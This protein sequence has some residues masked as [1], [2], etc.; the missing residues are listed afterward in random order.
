MCT[1]TSTSCR[2][3]PPSCRSSQRTDSASSTSVQPGGSML[4]Q[5]DGT[6]V[7]GG[8]GG[9]WVD[10]CGVG[11]VRVGGGGGQVPV[12][13][14]PALHRRS[15]AP[16]PRNASNPH[17]QIKYSGPRRSRRA[18]TS[19]RGMTYSAD[20]AMAGSS[21]SAPSLQAGTNRG[22][23]SEPA[24]GQAGGKQAGKARRGSAREGRQVWFADPACLNGCQCTPLLTSTPSV[25]LLHGAWGR[26]VARVGA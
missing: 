18:A 17:L 20:E 1:P 25:S 7:C 2:P 4:W 8:G 26:P 22:R 13:L 21:R 19:L 11:G 16:T 12:E 5:K 23:A 14:A 24:D 6:H 15:P 9:V 10:V 3:P